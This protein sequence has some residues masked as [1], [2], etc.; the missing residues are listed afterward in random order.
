MVKLGDLA[1]RLL[2][3]QD[4]ERVARWQN[5]LSKYL[6]MIKVAFQHEDFSEEDIE[7]FQDIVDEWFFIC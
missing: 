6:D 7:D 3:D 2:H 4:E 5:M 1:D